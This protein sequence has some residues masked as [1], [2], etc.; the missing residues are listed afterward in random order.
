MGN[1]FNLNLITLLLYFA[2]FIYGLIA[3]F[4][5]KSPLYFK[6]LF[7]GVGCFLLEDLYYLVDYVCTG[8][9]SSSFSFASFGAGGCYAFMFSANYG[10]FDGI[11]D[12]GSES[13]LKARKLGFVFPAILVIIVCYSGY[14]WIANGGAIY[15]TILLII[16]KLPAFPASYYHL[17]HL[18]IKDE[19]N[20]ILTFLRPCN[21]M[22]LCVILADFMY[23]GLNLCGYLTAAFIVKLFIPISLFGMMMA[24]NWGCKKWMI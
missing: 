22:A 4:R 20:Y 14:I 6:L 11:V 9:I 17:K 18:I 16:S 3:V 21:I 15:A 5:R 12:D 13:A 2:A 19:L 7:L 24:A 10:L 23:E 1:I 8:G